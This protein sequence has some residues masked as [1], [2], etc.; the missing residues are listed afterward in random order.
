MK[1]WNS[2]LIDKQIMIIVSLNVNSIAS[3]ERRRKILKY[4]PSY[5]DAD[6]VA[7]VDTR[8]KETPNLFPITIWCSPMLP[9]EKKHPSRGV[10]LLIRK[11]MEYK[12]VGKDMGGNFVICDVKKEGYLIRT[13]ALYAPNV[14]GPFFSPD[15]ANKYLYGLLELM[16]TLIKWD[17]NAVIRSGHNELYP[18]N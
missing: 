14:D 2:I 10:I 16:P 7:L 3:Y 15:I 12:T 11:G 6:I 13:V 9:K 5:I 17:F 4:V 18:W 8:V 1:E